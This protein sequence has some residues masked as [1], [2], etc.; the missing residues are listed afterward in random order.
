MQLV[1]PARQR[2]HA[3]VKR[4]GK[5]I[6]WATLLDKI[7]V[8]AARWFLTSG[9]TRR[10]TST[11]ASQCERTA[12]SLYIDVQYAHTHFI[13]SVFA[14]PCGRMGIKSSSLRRILMHRC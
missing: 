2:G 5:A 6:S 9:R 4:T 8:D 12:E 14:Q 3:H 1:A 7:P 10:W 13:C 11:S